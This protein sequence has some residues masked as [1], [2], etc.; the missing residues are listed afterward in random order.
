MGPR[1]FYGML[2]SGRGHA[3]RTLSCHVCVFGKFGSGEWKW[4]PLGFYR[5]SNIHLC[6]VGVWHGLACTW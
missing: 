1:I 6:P 5:G 4:C 3:F 2:S